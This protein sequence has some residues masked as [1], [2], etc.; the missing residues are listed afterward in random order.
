M[1]SAVA[2]AAGRPPETLPAAEPRRAG[3]PGS[4]RYTTA[5]PLRL[6][7]ELGMPASRLAEGAVARLLDRPQV[8]GARVERGGFVGIEVAPRARAAMVRTAAADG[9]G[10][11]Y[12]RLGPPEEAPVPGSPARTQDPWALTP[13]HDAGTVAEA[14]TRARGDARRRMLAAEALSGSGTADGDT[15]WRDPHLDRGGGDTPAARLL[16][17]VGEASARTAFCRSPAE[18][19]RPGEETG[20]GLPAVPTAEHPGAWALGTAA[21]PAFAIRYAHAHAVSTLRWADQVREAQVDGSV[22][23][24]PAAHGPGPGA[25][26]GD[27]LLAAALEAAPAAALAGALFDGPLVLRAAQRRSEPHMLVRYLEGLAAAYHEWR[28]SGGGLT[29]EAIGEPAGGESA[30]SRLRLCAAAAG[31][32]RAGSALLGVSAPTR[33]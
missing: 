28:N 7:R 27:A 19:P 9:A 23:S 18:Q 32:L 2:E 24:G 14:R 5:L 10:F 33:L 17:V 12:A 4:A 26:P 31:V 15:S 3:A 1:R 13:L 25:D 8:A 6:A 20:P 29:V 22:P 16:A 21:N 11:L 30:S